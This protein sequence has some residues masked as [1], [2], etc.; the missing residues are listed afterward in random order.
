MLRVDPKTGGLPRFVDV[1][2]DRHPLSFLGL[3]LML[4]SQQT[5]YGGRSAICQLSTV[6]DLLVMLHNQDRNGLAMRDL[7][8][9]R[10]M[11]KP[12]LLARK[13]YVRTHLL[14]RDALKDSLRAARLARLTFDGGEITQESMVN[15][16]W[17]MLSRMGKDELAERLR[18]ILEE[19]E[20]WKPDESVD[21][22]SGREDG[23]DGV[24]VSEP[25]VVERPA[26]KRE[27]EPS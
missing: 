23:R 7:I 19:M 3:L 8:N 21:A 27:S 5:Q 24:P 25:R 17:V 13:L 1:P 16:S 22:V 18:P 12:P 9:I 10:L 2:L 26:P 6:L 14:S 15:A 20:T 4:H 11:R